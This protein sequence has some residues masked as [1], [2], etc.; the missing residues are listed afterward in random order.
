MEPLNGIFF[1]FAILLMV[2]TLTYALYNKLS[3]W[4]VRVVGLDKEYCHVIVSNKLLTHHEI[5]GREAAVFTFEEINYI[6]QPK[7]VDN[8]V[9]ILTIPGKHGNSKEILR[10]DFTKQKTQT[11]EKTISI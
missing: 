1:G 6:W 7:D 4:G 9:Y 2:F 10:V 11:H 8:D 5:L 3:H